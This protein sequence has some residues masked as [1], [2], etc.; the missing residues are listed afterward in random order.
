MISEFI[1]NRSPYFFTLNDKS[2]LYIQTKRKS[3]FELCFHEWIIII[4]ST[5]GYIFQLVY[6]YFFSCYLILNVNL[7]YYSE[8]KEIP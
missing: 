7:K 1:E 5:F 8:M 2:K 6:I 4:F 3:I